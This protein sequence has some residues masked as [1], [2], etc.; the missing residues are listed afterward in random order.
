MTSADA[1]AWGLYTHVYYAQ[2]LLWAVP[3]ADKRFRR[4]AA[5]FPRLVV[6]GACLPDLSLVTPGSLGSALRSTH[7]WPNVARLRQA[8]TDDVA[9]ALA[10]SCFSH[11]LSD[12]IAHNH[13]VP[14]HE[15]VWFNAPMVTHALCEWAM[16]R[17][18]A[19]Q[20]FSPPHEV[21]RREEAL[22]ADFVTHSFGCDAEYARRAVRRLARADQWLRRSR[23]P[24]AVHVTARW[25][26][27]FLHRRFNHYLA[28]T[29]SRLHQINRLLG[30]ELPEWQ[31]EI[32]AR[33]AKAALGEY[34]LQQLRAR[35]PLPADLFAKELEPPVRASAR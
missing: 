28:E 8:A 33:Q 14:V 27:G 31:A 7:Q 4:A 20:I 21:L 32:C 1:L 30:G 26:D 25:G 22:V 24:G 5:R 18:V 11:L 15:S 35:L 9:R 2:I 16:D 3:L 17:Y 19:A 10:L 34:S 6:A 23:L 29:T 13:F 12:V